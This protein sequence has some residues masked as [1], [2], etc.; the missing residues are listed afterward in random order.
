MSY[1]PTLVDAFLPNVEKIAKEV[2]DVMY[3]NA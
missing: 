2:K 3:V 1:A